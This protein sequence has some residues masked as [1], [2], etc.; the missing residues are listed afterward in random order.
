MKHKAKN[1]EREFNGFSPETVNFLKKL[2]A[3]NNREWFEAHRQDYEQR[4]LE[5]MRNLVAELGEFML[6]IDPYFEI[7]PAVNKTISRI[8][9]DTRFS[10]DKS[11]FRAR[12]WIAFKRPIEDWQDSPGYF[13]E[14][15]HDYY[16]Y[17]MGFY[18]ATRATMDSFRE[19]IDDKPK[20]FQKLIAP[21]TKQRKFVVEGEE[22]KREIK[23]NQPEKIQVWYQKKNLYLVY[24]S[25]I[26]RRLFKRDL[27]DELIS[28]FSL[29][30]PLYHYLWEAREHG[31]M[32]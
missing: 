31:R 32:K 10:K 13:F 26:N 20:H 27:L 18:R 1:M 19:M 24:R 2:K 16:D 30:A 3:N 6:V 15:N 28:S 8:F 21:L 7:A 14:I 11:P 23:N 9:R 4:L 25:K 12:M 29:L 17:G 22:Y 5:P